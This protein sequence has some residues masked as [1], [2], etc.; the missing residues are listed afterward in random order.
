MICCPVL[1]SNTHNN[2]ARGQIWATHFAGGYSHWTDR[3]LMSSS[4][5]IRSV[6]VLTRV[7]EGGRIEFLI[8]SRPFIRGLFYSWYFFFFFWGLLATI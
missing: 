8:N 3:Q 7:G 6:V 5:W 4:R 1:M 2:D